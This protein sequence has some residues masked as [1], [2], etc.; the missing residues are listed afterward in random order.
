MSF[1]GKKIYTQLSLVQSF[2]KVKLIQ[3]YK[4]STCMMIKN[5]QNFKIILQFLVKLSIMINDNFLIT[6]K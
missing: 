2:C 6:E 5:N 1:G 3:A 4:N